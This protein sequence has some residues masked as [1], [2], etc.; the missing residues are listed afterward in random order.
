M[1][2]QKKEPEFVRHARLFELLRQEN[3]ATEHAKHTAQPVPEPQM[4][5]QE[6]LARA[7]GSLNPRG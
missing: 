1:S 2:D 6:L 5:E 3:I 4:S 7:L